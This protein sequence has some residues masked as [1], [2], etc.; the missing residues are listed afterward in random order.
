[1]RLTVLS[2][3]ILTLLVACQEPKPVKTKKVSE[4]DLIKLN[5]SISKMEALAIKRFVERQEWPMD[6][7][8]TGLYIWEYWKGNGYPIEVGDEVE[9]NL[10]V[11]LLNGDTCY[12]YKRY[13]SEKFEVEKADL[14][15]GL[16]EAVQL[17]SLN[18]KAKIILP[19]HLAH[20]FVGDRNK[21]PM[22]ASVVYDMEIINHF[23]H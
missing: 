9:V 8:G 21:I 15:S 20:G 14:E 23:P 5:Q 6:T 22:N 3:A 13:G 12:S 10:T 11:S 18:S 4:E 1:M 17:L 16:H 2:I 7:T 19:P